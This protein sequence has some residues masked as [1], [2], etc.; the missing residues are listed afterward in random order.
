MLIAENDAELRRLGA[1]MLL[2]IHDELIFEVP[3]DPEICEMATKRVKE[4]MEHPFSFDLRVPIPAS[5]GVADSWAQ[6]K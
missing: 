6:A 5:G 4:I 1:S 2:Q 3:D